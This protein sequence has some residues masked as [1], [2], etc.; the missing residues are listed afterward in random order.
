MQL[1]LMNHDVVAVQHGQGL[2]RGLRHLKL[3]DVALFEII[4]DTAADADLA[5][6]IRSSDG[7]KN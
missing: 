5:R 2:A 3:N 7:Q 6:V 1:E 4:S